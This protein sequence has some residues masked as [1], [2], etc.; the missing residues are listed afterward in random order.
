ME[1]FLLNQNICTGY[2]TYD[3]AVVC[4]ENEIEARKIH[5]SEFVTHEKNGN[6][7][8]TRNDGSE[9]ENNGYD[10]VDFKP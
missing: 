6:W 2:D 10:W 3:L 7:M 8:G 5:P 9:Y 4:A 1:L